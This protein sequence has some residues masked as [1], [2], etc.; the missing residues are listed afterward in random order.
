MSKIKAVA[1]TKKLYQ[2]HVH[3]VDEYAKQ[4]F[5]VLD[6][7]GVLADSTVIV[8]T[9]HG[10]EFGDH[11]GLSHDGKMYAELVHVPQLVVNPPEGR[12]SQCDT[13]VSGLDIPPTVMHLFGFEDHPNFQGRSLFPLSK[14]PETGV[15]GEAI[16]KLSHKIKETDR[17]AYYYRNRDFKIMYREEDDR[18][19]LYDMQSDPQET[20]NIVDTSP[21]AEELKVELK[22]KIDRGTKTT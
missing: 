11:G 17:P 21:S 10:D 20:S 16:G 3:E 9:D 7:H 22:P 19:E 12:G 6:N 4:L 13:L 1:Q 5:G 14:Y 15:Y 2:A 8:T 18:W